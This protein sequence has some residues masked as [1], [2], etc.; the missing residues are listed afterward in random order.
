MKSAINIQS[1]GTSWWDSAKDIADAAKDTA[2]DLLGDAAASDAAAGVGSVV[3]SSVLTDL[4]AAGSRIATDAA[5]THAAELG[6]QADPTMVQAQKTLK[7]I[8]IGAAAL[9]IG[10]LIFLVTRRKRK[11]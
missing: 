4:E 9:G 2:G 3:S 11:K 6:Q 1:F 5:R 10:G 8:G 7:W